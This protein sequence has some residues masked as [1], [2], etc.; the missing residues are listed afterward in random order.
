MLPHRNRFFP[1][2]AR[3]RSTLAPAVIGAVSLIGPATEAAG[4]LPL[5]SHRAVYEMSLGKSTSGSSVVAVTG[6]MVVEFQDVCDGFTL[7]QRVRTDM[8]DTDGDVST[9]DFTIA[10]WE[11]KDG[12][13]FRFT[14]KHELSGEPTEEYVGNAELRGSVG[15]FATMTKPEATQLALPGGTVFP[16]EHLRQLVKAAIDGRQYIPV[17]V[18]DGS[19]EDGLFETG[20]HLGKRLAD[21]TEGAARSLKGVASWPVR[22]AYFNLIEK[23]ETPRYEVAFRMYENGVSGDLVLDYGEFGMKGRLVKLEL[24]PKPSC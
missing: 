5:A 9:S 10:S 2:M 23:Q 18:F 14:L 20:A 13:R 19:G 12:K 11:S 8:E 7:N 22:I 16:T 21:E 4:P 1:D 3:I 24:L 17:R 6:T 15:G